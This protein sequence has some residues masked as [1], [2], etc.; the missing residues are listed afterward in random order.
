MDQENQTFEE[1]LSR[2]KE[3]IDAIEN[4]QLPLEESVRR[5]EQGI[6]QLNTLEKELSEMKRRITV[7]LEQ[8][9]GKLAET[10]LEEKE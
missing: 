8:P 5:Y 2:V 4:G 9:D 3:I 7:L 6:Q 10:P 1:R